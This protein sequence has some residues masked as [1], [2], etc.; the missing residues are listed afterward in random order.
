M[1]RRLPKKWSRATCHVECTASCTRPIDCARRTV[2][3][4]R[5]VWRK[6]SAERG[7]RRRLLL[8][9]RRHQRLVRPEEVL[10]PGLLDER[11]PEEARLRRVEERG[12]VERHHVRG[13]REDGQ[14]TV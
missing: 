6:R 5:S 10:D 13:V 4:W 2:N 14:L 7:R 1:R 3:A 11:R 12:V 9:Q 8:L